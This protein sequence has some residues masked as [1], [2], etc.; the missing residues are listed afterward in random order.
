M[1][2]GRRHSC[3]LGVGG[4]VLAP[5]KFSGC[6]PSPSSEV[7]KERSRFP[8]GNTEL[9]KQSS[10]ERVPGCPGGLLAPPGTVRKGR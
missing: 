8:S 2:A 7:P 9:R 3:E 10:T 1:P 5:N 6:Q 4:V